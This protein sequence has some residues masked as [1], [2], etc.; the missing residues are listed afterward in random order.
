MF[1]ASLLI[2]APTLAW[3]FADGLIRLE[4]I[5]A[6]QEEYSYGYV[7]PLISLFLVWQNGDRLERLGATGSWSGLLLVLFGMCLYALGEWGAIYSLVQYAFVVV[8]EGLALAWLGP[9]AFRLV[10]IPILM[11]AFTVPLPGFIQAGLTQRFQLWS[12][13]LGVWFIRLLGISVYLEGNVIDLGRFKLQVVEACSGLRYLFPLMTLGFILAYFFQA[14][15]WKRAVLFVSTI[16]ITILMNSLRIGIIGIMVEFWGPSMAQ[17]FLH[18]FEGWL[19]FMACLGLLLTEMAILVRLG[20]RPIPFSE[21]LNIR[22]PERLRRSGR[23]HPRPGPFLAASAALFGLA[24]AVSIVPRPDAADIPERVSLSEFPMRIGE[25][26][27]WFDP[28]DPRFI[29]ALNFDDYVMANYRGADGATINLYIAYYASQTKAKV[30]H[31]PQACI[32]GGGWAITR[33]TEVVPDSFLERPIEVASDR[34]PLRVNS[35]IIEKAGDRRLVYYWFQQ[36]GRVLTSQWAV[37]WAIFED[38]LRRHRTDGALVR[39]VTSIGAGASGLER[40]HRR[41]SRFAAEI[42]PMLP[43]FVPD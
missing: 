29:D 2:L 28:L 25:W 6:N 40:A 17:G 4:V 27:G 12:S 41:L 21:A 15:L 31:S 42:H 36:R 14:S 35:L 37:K 5:W 7:V 11:L 32:P 39:L 34:P 24:V 43:R 19:V 38:A 9:R 26:E 22:W 30:P 10:A 3:L 16:P 33:L 23:H 13:E 1:P 20:P 8:L 18:D